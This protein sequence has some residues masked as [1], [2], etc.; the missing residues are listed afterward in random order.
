MSLAWSVIA[1]TRVAS[2]VQLNVH[3]VLIYTLCTYRNHGVLTYSY[4]LCT[5]IPQLY[6]ESLN[7]HG[8]CTFSQS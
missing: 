3:G 7:V 6:V 1:V 4:T 2:N 5:G 8:V